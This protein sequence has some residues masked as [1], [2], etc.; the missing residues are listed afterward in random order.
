MTTKVVS[1]APITGGAATPSIIATPLYLNH[2][3]KVIWL[4]RLRGRQTVGPT[5]PSGI[6]H[7]SH[8]HHFGDFRRPPFF[9]LSS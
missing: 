8:H 6:I 5:G 9:L 7:R 4:G 3:F 2:V 1:K